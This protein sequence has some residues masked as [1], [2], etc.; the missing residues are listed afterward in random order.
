M[1]A[2]TRVDFYFHWREA[3]MP[4]HRLLVIR[5]QCLAWLFSLF[6][7]DIV[8]AQDK[9]LINK[10]QLDALF[11]FVRKG[12]EPP[13][14]KFGVEVVPHPL[15]ARIDELVSD[16]PVD[17]ELEEGDI[18]VSYHIAA[19]KL[20]TSFPIRTKADIDRL[21][22]FVRIGLT[23]DIT[24]LR[25]DPNRAGTY[26]QFTVTVDAGKLTRQVSVT[27]D[28]EAFG[29]QAQLWSF[30]EKSG[31]APG[32][33]IDRIEDL[34]QLFA[35]DDA[36]PKTQFQVNAEDWVNSGGSW[37]I[38]KM[39]HA[40][41][42]I[43]VY[44]IASDNVLKVKSG[45]KQ[46][47]RVLVYYATDRERDTKGRY[48]GKRSP[49]ADPVKYGMCKVSIPAGSKHKY[50][51]LETPS[52]WRLEFS[53]NPAKHVV[54]E[55]VVEQGKDA[56]LE[57]IGQQLAGKPG[58]GKHRVLVFVHGFN[59]T[60]DDAA[61]R[62]AQLH[63]DLNFPG[64]TMFY[65]WPSNGTA[66]GYY[67]DAEDIKW[68]T[69]H[70]ADFLKSLED[71]KEVDEIIVLAHSMG[72]RG[73]TDAL[74]EIKKQKL[75]TKIK[76]IILAAPDI[77]ADTFSREIA[78]SIAEYYPRTTIYASSQDRALLAAQT[79]SD[80]K[81]VGQIVNGQFTIEPRDRFDLIDASS[82]FTE[83]TGHLYYGDGPTV[84][85]DIYEILLHGSLPPRQF[86]KPDGKYWRFK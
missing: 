38:G 25:Q 63:Y 17:E 77:D 55:K 16:R 74:V 56:T 14:L 45:K 61:R 10:D 36:D 64:V 18:F 53:P 62:S 32:P 47:A 30:D 34:A 41:G 20:D 54:L 37:P 43:N 66:T 52:F 9:P 5:C 1:N 31:E 27:S 69:S 7:G 83:L 11:T 68:A 57:S 84:I 70:I 22:E 51:R 85:S 23:V 78:P 65:S 72:N 4:Y 28:S 8:V 48:T 42:P 3:T 39:Y 40:A 86:L 15:G 24:L 6:C 82:V 76:E 49:E 35:L 60:F 71:Q 73:V 59:V 12:T 81:R 29:D 75:G 13:R 26:K 19:G 44:N 21:I 80:N 50:G 79:I 46:V 67:S 2:A 33:R 58:K